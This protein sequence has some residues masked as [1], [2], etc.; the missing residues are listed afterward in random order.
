VSPVAF[1]DSFDPIAFG[2]ETSALRAASIAT[3][4]ERWRSWVS[5]DLANALALSDEA[6]EARPGLFAWMFPTG[7]R[8]RIE[9]DAPRI[10]RRELAEAVRADQSLRDALLSAFDRAVHFLGLAQANGALTWV[11]A[12]RP[13]CDKSA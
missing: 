11:G 1:I 6:I 13:G 2:D 7:A 5:V 10:G 8:S 12:P 4:I 3:N 9:P